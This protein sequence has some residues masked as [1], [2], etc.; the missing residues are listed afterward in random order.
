METIKTKLSELKTTQKE[1]LD[2]AKKVTKALEKRL[3]TLQDLPHFIGRLRAQ[4]LQA[5]EPDGVWDD[6]EVNQIP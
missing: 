5:A 6:L 2:L 3:A 4:E 1:S